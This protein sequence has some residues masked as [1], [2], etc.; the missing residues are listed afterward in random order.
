MKDYEHTK[1]M[2]YVVD[3]D[4]RLGEMVSLVLNGAGYDCETFLDGETTL[5]AMQVRTPDLLLLDY[6]LPDTDGVE[7]LRKV[8]ETQ[9]SLPI[10]MMSGQGTI[11][12]AVSSIQ[13]G[14]FDF[15]E[16]P[17]DS[18]RLALSVR[19][20]LASSQLE[21]QVGGL[22]RVIEEQFRMVGDSP[23]L[24]HVRDL[25]ARV[26]PT[27]A[28]VLITGE[29][30][31]GKELVA[32]AIHL[33]S[34]R[35]AE[36]FAALNC[37]AIPKELIESELFG[38]EKGAFTGA[39][40]SRRGKLQDADHGTLFLDEIGDMSVATQAKLLRFLENMEIQRLGGSVIVHLD[41][42]LIA[43]TNKD[44]A[45][46]IKEGTFRE[47]LYHRLNVVAILVPPLRER[48]ADIM[49]LAGYFLEH[50]CRKHNRT[51]SFAPDCMQV[52]TGHDWPGN[53]RELRNV[54]ERA[55][56]LSLSDPIEAE[57]LR[58][59]LG[60]AARDQTSGALEAAVL[61]AERE[62]LEQALEQAHGNVTEAAR[63]LGVPRPSIYRIMKRHGL[64]RAKSEE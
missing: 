40:S 63:I 24:E 5:A 36:T 57:E 11:R 46:C 33:K 12:A 25:V 52:L 41:V 43:A 61:R 23:A 32:R 31:V 51:R 50:F 45:A 3:D 64:G 18:D 6:M 35:V 10:I 38:Y 22:K 9:P 28:S 20:A 49:P 8:R 26:A 56:V 39:A 42:R 60:P 53:V 62:S 55:V 29:S 54:V 19:N 16:K 48:I 15:L 27:T 37:A 14:A 7:L 4:A 59:F 17:L 34:P 30:G 21:K 58:S 44:L 13:L 47:D 1:A 2:I